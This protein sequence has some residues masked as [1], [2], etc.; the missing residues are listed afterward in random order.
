MRKGH[1]C[2]MLN[3]ELEKNVIVIFSSPAAVEFQLFQ[4]VW[5]FGVRIMV[6]VQPAV[7]YDEGFE[8]RTGIFDVFEKQG[9][10]GH[11]LT[12]RP[13]PINGSRHVHSRTISPFVVERDLVEPRNRQL[14][15]DVRRD[16]RQDSGQEMTDLPESSR[17]T[18]VHLQGKEYRFPL[19]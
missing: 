19:E 1:F 8:A 6:Q 18:K 2:N 5:E 10:N 17:K 12:K 15:D 3:F 9:C 14:L 16:G 7:S 13:L 11:P 4:A